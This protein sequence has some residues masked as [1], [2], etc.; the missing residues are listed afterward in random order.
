MTSDSVEGRGLDGRKRVD[1]T[2]I[3]ETVTIKNLRGK[4][5]KY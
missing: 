5:A 3:L 4:G 1:I 2:W